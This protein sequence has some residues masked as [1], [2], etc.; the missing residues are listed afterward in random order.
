MD[1]KNKP[2]YPGDKIRTVRVDEEL[3]RAAH[4]KA[5]KQREPLS[6]VIRRAL[7]AYVGNEA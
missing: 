1:P 6:E 3:W 5:H 2:A 4:A 7:R